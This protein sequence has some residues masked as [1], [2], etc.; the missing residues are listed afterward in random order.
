MGEVAQV[1]L[2]FVHPDRLDPHA[3]PYLP[4]GYIL[5]LGHEVGV[6]AVQL[7]EGEYPSLLRGRSR[8][9]PGATSI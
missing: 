7:D 3:D 4:L 5:Q 9:P 8:S 1:P 2:G 6:H